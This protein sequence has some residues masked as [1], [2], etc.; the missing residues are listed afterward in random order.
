MASSPV[1]DLAA[2][3]CCLRFFVIHHAFYIQTILVGV[4]EAE[5]ADGVLDIE[6]VLEIER[7]RLGIADQ[8]EIVGYLGWRY[9]ARVDSVSLEPVF[10]V[11]TGPVFQGLAAV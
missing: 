7:D 8:Q 3:R 4:A 9:G 1:D 2:G 11:L 5:A 10:H 6:Q